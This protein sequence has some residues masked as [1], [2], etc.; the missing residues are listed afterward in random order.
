MKTLLRLL[1]LVLV[2]CANDNTVVEP[3]H[4]HTV[5]LEAQST[6][7][8]TQV[9]FAVGDQ[10]G[11]MNLGDQSFFN[12]LPRTQV[13]LNVMGTNPKAFGGQTQLTGIVVATIYVDGARWKWDNGGGDI[14]GSANATGILP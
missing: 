6:F 5:R 11:Q 4:I 10:N 14:Y 2:G 3:N 12:V 9:N 1:C 13:T 7:T 8:S